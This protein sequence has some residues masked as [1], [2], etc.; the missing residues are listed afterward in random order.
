MNINE[1]LNSFDGIAAPTTELNSRISLVEVAKE[2]VE[3]DF[4]RFTSDTDDFVPELLFR[5]KDGGLG[6]VVLAV[7][8]GSESDKDSLAL[9]MFATLVMHGVTE[10]VFSSSSWTVRSD[11]VEQWKIEGR[12]APSDFSLRS[13]EVFVMHFCPDG[14]GMHHANINRSVGSGR[15]PTLGEWQEE[16]LT[17]QRMGGRFADAIHNGLTMAA[18]ITPEVWTYMQSEISQGR[19]R[20]VRDSLVYAAAKAQ[21]DFADHEEQHPQMTPGCHLCELRQPAPRQDA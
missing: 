6:A 11:H 12:P 17:G 3:H 18:Q 13:E 19:G 20:V 5:S 15:P 14:E 2:S 1:F 7:E 21:Q 9:V 16:A 10:A 8:M 4:E